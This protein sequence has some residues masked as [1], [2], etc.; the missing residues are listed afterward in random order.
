MKDFGGE[1]WDGDSS[2]NS[3]GKS[4]PC[5]EQLTVNPQRS[6]FGK[7]PVTA[8]VRSPPACPIREGV[9]GVDPGSST[10]GMIVDGGTLGRT[11]VGIR[12]GVDI[13]PNRVDS[14]Y[15]I[16]V[17]SPI[18]IQFPVAIEIRGL[19]PQIPSYSEP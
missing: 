14:D 1:E 5:C 15:L 11:G 16:P 6:G 19:L 4:P 10:C 7:N 2:P 17:A 8:R 18:Q 13:H 9:L 3:S 12:P